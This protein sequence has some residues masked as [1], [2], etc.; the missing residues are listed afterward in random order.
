MN[1]MRMHELRRVPHFRKDM[2]EPAENE[3]ADSIASNIGALDSWATAFWSGKGLFDHCHFGRF[4]P[5]HG[6]T[7]TVWQLSAARDCVMSIYHFGRTIEGIDASLGRCPNLT[8]NIDTKAKRAAAKLFKRTFRFFIKIRHA[9]A[10]AAERSHTRDT[11][12]RHSQRG[13][14][15][16]NLGW[17]EISTPEDDGGILMMDHVHGE[18]FATMWEGEVIRCE[19]NE[20]TGRIL[21]DIVAQYWTAFD[22]VIDP[23][24]ADAP[25]VTWSKAPQA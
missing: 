16:I 21:D 13:R 15:P 25:T 12:R 11:F 9:L 2:I 5:A 7:F 23:N 20:G 19:I 4:D 18:T 8:S 3:H 14:A 24:P 6:A 22:A 17:L 10:H 1:V